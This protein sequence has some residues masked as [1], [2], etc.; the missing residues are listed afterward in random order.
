VLLIYSFHSSRLLN[1]FV[2]LNFITKKLNAASIVK[3]KKLKP[4]K[5]L[6][7]EFYG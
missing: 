1:V 2:P 4:E 7:L 3:T 6:A 5:L